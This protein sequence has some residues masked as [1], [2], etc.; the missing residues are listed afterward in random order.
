MSEEADS[1]MGGVSPK[2]EQAK[3]ANGSGN[4][5]VDSDATG[6]RASKRLKTEDS[7]LSQAAPV[8]DNITP[9]ENL[10][11]A[12]SGQDNA[13]QTQGEKGQAEES[14]TD[15]RPAHVDGRAKGLAQIKKE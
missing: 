1:K 8:F 9:G 12:P 3:T 15:S 10:G 4:A 13:N 5:T 7:A 6:E 14:K 2:A 11:D